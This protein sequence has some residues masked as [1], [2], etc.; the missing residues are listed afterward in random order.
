MSKSKHR[1]MLDRAR[2]SLRGLGEG[3]R[4][5][6]SVRTHVVLAVIGLTTLL[7]CRVEAAWS[8]AFAVLLAAGLAVEL[9]NAALEAM[10]DLLHPE[11]HSEVG[12]AKDM[13]SAG[14]F[15]LNTV[16]AFTFVLALIMAFAF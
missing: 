14:A 15:V 10:A 13:S 6:K 3:W 12:A 1:P 9:L 4:R 2:D 5:E 8:L 11:L 7:L 16:A